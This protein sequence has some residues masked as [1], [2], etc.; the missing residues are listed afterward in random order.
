MFLAFSFP[1]VSCAIISTTARSKFCN[2]FI[3]VTVLILG[4][5]CNVLF[6]S[7]KLVS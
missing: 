2:A 7:P 1:Y 6:I 4:R 5:A 3:F